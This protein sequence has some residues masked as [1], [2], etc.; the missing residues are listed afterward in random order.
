[1]STLRAGR[2]APS[3]AAAAAD[4]NPVE[5]R[6]RRALAWYPAEWRLRHGDAM[7]GV[8]MDLA[9]A[10]GASGPRP[11][12]RLDLAVHG[13]AERLVGRFP[14]SARSLTATSAFLGGTAFALFHFVFFEWEPWA[15]TNLAGQWAHPFST[16]SAWPELVWLAGALCFLVGWPRTAKAFVGLAAALALFLLFYRYGHPSWI[17]P[18]ASTLAATIIPAAFVFIGRVRPHRPAVSLG[19]LAGL[20]AALAA[21]YRFLGPNTR[22][23]SNWRQDDELLWFVPFAHHQRIVVILLPVALAAAAVALLAA[24]RVRAASALTA[25]GLPWAAVWAIHGL[26]D[27]IFSTAGDLGPLGLTVERWA[28]AAALA[29][30][31][32]IVVALWRPLERR[33]LTHG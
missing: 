12:Q 8:L 4:V 26:H 25:V 2:A 23:V 10:E 7:L 27:G 6:M 15:T 3:L 30:A 31:F 20:V 24:G 9:E 29:A 22:L 1:M 32:V 11:A 21:A 5:S 28:F 14:A 19:A 16:L 17:W 18:H 33:A 13:L